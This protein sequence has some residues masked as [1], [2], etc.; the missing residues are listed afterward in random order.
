MNRNSSI[1]RVDTRHYRTIAKE[2]WGLTD[3]Q[4]KGMHVHHRVKRSEGGTNDPSN[5]YVCSPWFHGNIW[6]D[7]SYWIE[8]QLL[9]A[10]I[11]AKAVHTSKDELGRS[12]HAVAMRDKAWSTKTVEEVSDHCEM[13]RS[14]KSSEVD[15]FGRKI[16]HV[17]CGV[18]SKKIRVINISTNEVFIFDSGRLAERVLGVRHLNEVANG[19]RS[20]SKGFRAEWIKE[21]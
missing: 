5:L 6:H 9:K 11:G 8:T 1:V 4:M 10:K 12:E 14:F 21:G 13:M 17:P 16:S 3:E 7:E 15:E 18:K 2:N 19:T 20:Q